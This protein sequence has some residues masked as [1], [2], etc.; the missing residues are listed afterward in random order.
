MAISNEDFVVSIEKSRGYFLR[1]LQGL[2]IE[3]IDWK[4]YRECK[5]IIETLQHLIVDDRM[6]LESMKS[7]AEPDYSACIVSENDYDQLLELLAESH[8]ELTS[9]LRQRVRDQ[10]LEA[11]ACAWGA[12][13]PTPLAISYLASEDF[14]HAGQVSYIRMATDPNWDYYGAIYGVG[15]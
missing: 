14:F 1:H 7:M 15:E 9:Y 13:M 4:P 6:A 8:R 11:P 12:I 3:Q 2:H 5:N 10:P